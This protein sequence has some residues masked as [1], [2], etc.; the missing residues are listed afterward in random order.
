MQAADNSGLN[1]R[2]KRM[3]HSQ[4]RG[5]NTTK[6][7]EQ[8][9]TSYDYNDDN[10]DYYLT[11]INKKINDSVNR[12]VMHKVAVSE[13]VKKSVCHREALDEIKQK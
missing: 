13:K 5:Y 7:A 6:Y 3:S 1:S 12:S 2:R 9:R 4:M 8:F 10:V 11:K